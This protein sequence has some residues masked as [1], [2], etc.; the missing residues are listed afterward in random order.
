M[1]LVRHEYWL[2]LVGRE[3]SRETRESREILEGRKSTEV[4]FKARKKL[5]T[6]KKECSATVGRSRADD[7]GGVVCVRSEGS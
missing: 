6:K 3:R 5:V 2:K 1:A 4:G 7:C